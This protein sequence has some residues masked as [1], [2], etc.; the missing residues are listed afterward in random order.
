M[1]KQMTLAEIDRRWPILAQL[2]RA[3]EW[4][5]DPDLD[6]FCHNFTLQRDFRAQQTDLA[7][8]ELKHLQGAVIIEILQ[9]DPGDI[10]VRAP[11]ATEIL[12]MLNA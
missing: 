11:N 9:L 12:T 3:I 2:Q 4:H 6:Y 7:E 10:D 5:G 1:S 8:Y